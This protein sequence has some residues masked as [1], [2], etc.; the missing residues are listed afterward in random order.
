MN[1]NLLSEQVSSIRYKL[2]CAYS[3]DSN[4]SAHQLSLIRVFAV[5]MKNHWDRATHRMPSK[6]YEQTANLRRLI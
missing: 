4:Q 2:A 1:I 5:D 3:K 6:D